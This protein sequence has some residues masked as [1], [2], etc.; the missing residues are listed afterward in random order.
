MGY[1]DLVDSIWEKVSIYDGPDVFLEQYAESPEPSRVLFSAHWCQ[2]EVCNGGFEQ[3]FY[4]STGILAPEAAEAFRKIG[5][6]QIA[7][8]IEQAMSLFGSNYPRDRSER[9]LALYVIC[10]APAD[11][12]DGPF[13]KLDQSFFD[14]IETENGGFESAA[15]AYA[16]QIASNHP[17]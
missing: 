1:W 15:D 3:F 17:S 10:M 2:S 14:L 6:P 4:N 9:D 8:L 12:E 13:S 5:M 7:V 16:T 11:D